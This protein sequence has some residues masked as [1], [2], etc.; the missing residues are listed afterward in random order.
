M[1][2]REYRGCIFTLL[3]AAPNSANKAPYSPPKTH[4]HATTTLQITALFSVLER[5]GRPGFLL[6]SLHSAFPTFSFAFAFVAAKQHCTICDIGIWPIA[7]A[8]SDPILL[9]VLG[10]PFAFP[11]SFFLPSP[12]SSLPGPSPN[13]TRSPTSAH[14]EPP[15]NLSSVDAP[16]PDCR[17]PLTHPSLPT[18]SSKSVLTRLPVKR[19]SQISHQRLFF[20]APLLCLQPPYHHDLEDSWIPLSFALAIFIAFVCCFPHRPSDHHTTTIT[21]R[22]SPYFTQHGVFESAVVCRHKLSA[23]VATPIPFQ[24]FPRQPVQSIVFTPRIHDFEYLGL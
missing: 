3:K 20:S 23:S 9:V 11:F 7:T 21:R 2:S 15:I 5:T 4:T 17:S 8:P 19:G 13:P 12:S 16:W 24:R 18:L 10:R 1:K 22:A 14:K 6:V